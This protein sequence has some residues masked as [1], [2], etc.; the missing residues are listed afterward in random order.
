MLS[1]PN[2]GLLTQPISFIGLPVAVVPVGTFEGLPV[3][4]QVICAPWREDLCLRVAAVLERMGVAKF[5]P[6]KEPQ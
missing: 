3:G 4:M 2:M 5:I 6:P 1:R